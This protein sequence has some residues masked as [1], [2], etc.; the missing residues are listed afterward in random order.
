MRPIGWAAHMEG[1]REVGHR[2]VVVLVHQLGF[3]RV[4]LVLIHLLALHRIRC[5]ERRASLL[6]KQQSILLKVSKNPAKLRTQKQQPEH[7]M[8]PT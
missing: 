5:C 3:A 1:V 4:V 6:A 2:V 8:H 7:V